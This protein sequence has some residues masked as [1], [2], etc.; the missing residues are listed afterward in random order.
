MPTINDIKNWTVK[1]V[2]HHLGHLRIHESN[3]AILQKHEVDGQTLLE[4]D[5][6]QWVHHPY[7]MGDGPARKIANEIEYPKNTVFPGV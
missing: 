2:L 7:N 5:R 3:F 1:D 6:N 4:L